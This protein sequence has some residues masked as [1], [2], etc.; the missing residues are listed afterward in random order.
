MWHCSDT[1]W[2]PTL[3][4]MQVAPPDD[5]I[6]NECKWCHSVTQFLTDAG[7]TT[8]WP[9]LQPI[10]VA[11]T[12]VKEWVRCASGKVCYQNDQNNDQNYQII[13]MMIMSIPLPA[14]ACAALVA[15]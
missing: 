13:K 6:L 3:E 8:L 1:N 7:G 2:W 4:P 10:Q 15:P 12:R 9:N 14:R 11:P 5:Q